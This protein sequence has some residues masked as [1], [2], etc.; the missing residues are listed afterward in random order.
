MAARTMR[1]CGHQVREFKSHFRPP[2]EITREQLSLPL[3]SPPSPS[4]IRGI[5][6][7]VQSID[8]WLV[9]QPHFV[10]EGTMKYVC[11]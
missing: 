7:V 4:G 2:S 6:W 1:Q 5:L 9:S 3:A 10:F 11:N 8:L